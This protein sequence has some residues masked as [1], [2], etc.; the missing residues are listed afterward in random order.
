MH[1]HVQDTSFR[2]GTGGLIAVRSQETDATL[3]QC[4]QLPQ[5]QLQE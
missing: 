3:S 2:L 1:M 5:L 4:A